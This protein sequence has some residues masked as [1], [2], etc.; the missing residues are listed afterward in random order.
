[1]S[2]TENLWTK[3]KDGNF[4]LKQKIETP[5]WQRVQGYRLPY[6]EY[7]KFHAIAR[8]RGIGASALT[9]EIIEEWL[10]VQDKNRAYSLL[11]A[12][13]EPLHSTNISYRLNQEAYEGLNESAIA[14]GLKRSKLAEMIV[15]G[16]LN[17]EKHGEK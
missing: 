9:K 17:L 6:A 3:D 7:I 5:V 1:V 8:D 15:R 16:W 13:F 2:G 14:L 10:S 12:T 4:V 11:L